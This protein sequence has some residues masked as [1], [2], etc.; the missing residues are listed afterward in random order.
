MRPLDLIR[1]CL[2]S[3]GRSFEQLGRAFV[4]PIA[5]TMRLSDLRLGIELAWTT[6]NTTEAEVLAG[7]MPWERKLADEFVRSGDSV[8]I[9]A[10]CFRFWRW[11]AG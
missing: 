1:A 5:G 7:W 10:T 2:F 8:L 11:V 4:Y 9:V 6:F 3:A